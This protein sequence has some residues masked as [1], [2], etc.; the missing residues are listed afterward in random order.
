MSSGFRS[1]QKPARRRSRNLKMA[2]EP[3]FQYRVIK[4]MNDPNYPA[5]TLRRDGTII[6]VARGLAMVNEAIS[7]ISNPAYLQI[8]PAFEGD[9]R[10][11]LDIKRGDLFV[12]LKYLDGTET[13]EAAAIE[14]IQRTRVN[15]SLEVHNYEIRYNMFQVLGDLT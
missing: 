1:H 7:A 11:P 6:P 2:I 14:H 15:F 10:V 4:D 9:P 3:L 8:T 12:R 5:L 13:T